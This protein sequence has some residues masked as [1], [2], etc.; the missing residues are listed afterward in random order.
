MSAIRRAVRKFLRSSV[1]DAGGREKA[2]SKSEDA[3][4]LVGLQY[5]VEA[6]LRGDELRKRVSESLEEFAQRYPEGLAVQPQ[7]SIEDT[8]E[9]VIV[10]VYFA[11]PAQEFPEMASHLSSIFAE[12]GL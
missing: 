6:S 9:G 7:P 12:N 10:T 11:G 3:A 2:G 8:P 1:G 5:V 4:P